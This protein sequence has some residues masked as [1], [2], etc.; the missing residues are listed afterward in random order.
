MNLPLDPPKTRSLWQ[1][2]CTTTNVT[3]FQN[4]IKHIDTVKT[5]GFMNENL[6][7]ITDQQRPVNSVSIY[8]GDYCFVVFKVDL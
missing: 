2:I 1:E 3:L 7:T 5:K 8:K 4:N 6:V